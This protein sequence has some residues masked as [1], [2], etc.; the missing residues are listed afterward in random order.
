MA[1]RCLIWAN[2]CGILELVHVV[3]INGGDRAQLLGGPHCDWGLS[4]LLRALAFMVS[5]S[6][7]K[8]GL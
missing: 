1:V 4:P 7:L 6:A 5:L 8:T 3:A 2:F